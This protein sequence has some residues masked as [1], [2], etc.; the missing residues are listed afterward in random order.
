MGRKTEALT[1]RPEAWKH[2][3]GLEKQ[4]MTN[5]RPWERGNRAE[6]LRMGLIPDFQNGDVMD[7]G[8]RDAHAPC[9][10][11]PQTGI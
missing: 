4:E 10:S 1:V 11:L 2:A 9:P 8:T 6:G 3:G 7:S 5:D